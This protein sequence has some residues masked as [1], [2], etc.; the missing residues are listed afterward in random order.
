MSICEHASRIHD[1][2][3]AKR[4]ASLQQIEHTAKKEKR[5]RNDAIQ[6]EL[7]QLRTEKRQLR[8]QLCSIAPGPQ[9]DNLQ[10]ALSVSYAEV[11][12][13]IESYLK[14]LSEEVYTT[15][16]TPQKSNRTPPNL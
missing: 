1:F 16:E 11:E 7:G 14:Q 12:E 9:H 2:A 10:N 5:K 8:I 13:E 6:L 15:M 4:Q 3:M